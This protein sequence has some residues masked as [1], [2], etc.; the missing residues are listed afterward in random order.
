[1]ATT[2]LLRHSMVPFHQL[3]SSSPVSSSFTNCV[4]CQSTTGLGG[5]KTISSPDLKRSER[6]AVVAVKASMLTTNRLTI[7]KPVLDPRGLSELLLA[8]IIASVRNA[9][10]VILLRNAV[11]KR[12]IR[13]RLHPQM[14]IERAIV[15]CRFFTLFAVAGSLLGSVLCFL[16][17]CVLVIESYA[18]YFHMLSQPSDQGHL[19]HLLIE[20]IDMFLVGTALLMFGVGLY[21]MFVGSCRATTTE[22]EPFGHLHIMK[23]APRWVGMQSIEQAK[24]KIGH[25]VMMILQVGL[26]DK[27]NNIPMVTGLDLACFAAALLTSSATIF[28]LSKLNQH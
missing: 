19:V 10:L 22:K 20:A 23:S 26:I 6:K 28:V 17:G 21:V 14:L 4:R 24:S 2:R 3:P 27:F 16:E 12:K 5:D 11:M 1:M 9:M 8:E 18:H 15:D 25:A 13:R 7:S